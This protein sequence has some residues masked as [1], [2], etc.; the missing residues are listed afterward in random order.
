M[1]SS[2]V[3]INLNSTI[4]GGALFF[5]LLVWF[6]DAV[7]SESIRKVFVLA[8]LST[9]VYVGALILIALALVFAVVR[10]MWS[11]S[12]DWRLAAACGIGLLAGYIVNPFWPHHWVYMGRELSTVFHV[13]ADIVVGQ[14][15][16]T[17]WSSIPGRLLVQVAGLHLALWL[18]LLVWQLGTGRRVNHQAAAGT[19]LVLGAL[20]AAMITAK[21][22]PLFF[23][24][25]ILFAPRLAVAM[26]PWP[27]RWPRW[28]LGTVAATVAVASL[29]QSFRDV[30]WHPNRPEPRQFRT[31]AEQL[32]T[33]T[34][35]GQVV[36][37]PWDDFPGLF[38]FNVHNT[39]VAGLNPLFLRW[40]SEQR[41]IAY[42]YL[43]QGRVEDPEALLP[44]FFGDARI[45]LVRTR[46]RTPGERALTAQL[47]RSPHFEEVRSLAPTWR[48][49]RLTRV[50]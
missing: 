6:L 43:Y 38:M 21:F 14:F 5:V 7:W 50:D 16:G 11:R 20:A 17:E 2:P 3:L 40:V 9:Y 44:T 47:A 18:V 41:Y 36:L 39:Y 42:S 48:M 25:S 28:M 4:K 23:I 31:A 45:V 37:A 1:F 34:P 46:G 15:F 30:H 12:W 13:P 8:W 19:V 32:R 26:G 10:G 33:I 29:A 22:L 35:A 27:G 49:F 24:V